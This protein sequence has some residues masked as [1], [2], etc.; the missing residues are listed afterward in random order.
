MAKFLQI[1]TR[2]CFHM[3]EGLDIERVSGCLVFFERKHCQ[4]NQ[5]VQLVT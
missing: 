2:Q 3:G 5:T 1:V 4:Q